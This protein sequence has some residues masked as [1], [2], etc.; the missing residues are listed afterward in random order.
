MKLTKRI[1]NISLILLMIILF[2]INISKAATVKITTETLN[3]R[4]EATTESNIVALISEGEEC[5]VLGEEGDWY[6]VQYGEYTGYISK[7]YAEL[8]SDDVETTNEVNNEVDEEV[9]N[10]TTVT[11]TSQTGEGEI[12]GQ[13]VLRITPLINSST[14]ENL[15]SGDKITVINQING[16][17]YIY[18]D[19]AAR[20]GKIKLCD[21]TKCRR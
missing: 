16:W 6:K 5:E 13:T 8:Q 2:H 3:L 10:E 21:F 12:N 20:M 7:E 17:S 14:L 15:K 11:S 18:T 4:K 19:E 1:L 9:D